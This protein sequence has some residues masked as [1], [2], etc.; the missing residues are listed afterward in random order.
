MTEQA[1]QVTVIVLAAGGG[2]RMRSKL[3]KVLHPIAGR[4]MVG[5]VMVA[6]DALNPAAVVAVIGH[7]RELVGPHLSDLRPDVVLAVQ[8]TQEGTAHAVRVGW[9]A[10]SPEQKQGTV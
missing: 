1:D 7:Q 5:H 2:T 8:E 3:P 10:L 4:S 6:V 9:E